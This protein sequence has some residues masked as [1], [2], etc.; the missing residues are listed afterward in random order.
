MKAIKNTEHL[1]LFY[2]QNSDRWQEL[3][4]IKEDDVQGSKFPLGCAF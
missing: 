3:E 2:D 4:I 1:Q